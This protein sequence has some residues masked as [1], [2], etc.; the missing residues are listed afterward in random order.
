MSELR[1]AVINS[2]GKS[3][4]PV[5]DPVGLVS[6]LHEL[7][8]RVLARTRY[9]HLFTELGTLEAAERV[10][11]EG[12]DGIYVDTFGD[13]AVDRIRAITDVPV[14]GAG[15]AT[16]AAAVTHGSFSIVTVWPRS[17]RWLYEERLSAVP[18]GDACAGVHHLA[19]EDELA[20]VGS[21]DGVK[22]RMTRRE[23]AVVDDIVA[24]CQRTV[25]HED[26]DVLVLGCTCM[27]PVAGAVAARVTVPVLDPARVGLAEAHRQVRSGRRRSGAL[28]PVGRRGLAST[29]VEAYLADDRAEPALDECEVCALTTVEE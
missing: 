20:K 28:P 26:P 24:L 2:D 17:M 19:D 14:V 22:A 13:Y 3:R 8:F 15:E 10:V 1:L 18:G 12:C 6:S 23:G 4:L 11:D 27:A 5:P 16:I 9:D 21:G 7:R 29:L 25:E